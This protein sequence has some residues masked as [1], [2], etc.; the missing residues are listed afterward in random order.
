MPGPNEVLSVVSRKHPTP[1]APGFANLVTARVDRDYLR[2]IKRVSTEL[3][4][5]GVRHALVGGMALGVYG[6]VRTTQDADFLI[7]RES[8]TRD[9][10]GTARPAPIVHA[11]TEN[12]DMSVDVRA[13]LAPVPAMRSSF[14][15]ALDAMLDRP[16]VTEGVPV[17]PGEYLV[18]LKLASGR[19][20][21]LAD[22]VRL[23]RAGLTDLERTRALLET[24][25][26]PATIELFRQLVAEV[27]SEK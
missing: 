3:S 21:D 26:T 7:G 24:H 23:L 15:G 2:E 9:P 14:L 18:A 25:A 1:S 20:D 5:A 12:A 22:I 4:A 19:R 17:A 13:L 11:I 16:F 27:A 8:V 6:Y 10:D